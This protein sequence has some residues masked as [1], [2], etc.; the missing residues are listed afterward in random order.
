MIRCLIADD[1]QI[2]QDILE[3]Y[4]LQSTG[5]TLVA[6]CRNALEAFARLEG[7]VVDLIFLDIE[8]PLINGLTFLRSLSN[9]PRVILTTAYADYA[10]EGYELNVV[11]YL[12]K[13]FSF[14]RFSKAIA[15]VKPAEV[16]ELKAEEDEGNLL[17][18]EKGG[19]KRVPYNKIIYIEASKDYM[20]IVTSDQQYL[21]HLT[22]KSLE[23]RLPV[24]R[25]VRI[26]KSYIVSLQQIRMVKSDSVVIGNNQSLP[27]GVNY[28]EQLMEMYK[29]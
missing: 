28:R 25:F 14:E 12:L 27:L 24:E 21:I 18:K 13:P 2:A 17:I 16:F 20:K 1:E 29:K 23:S 19:L 26:H 5:L 11:D 4:I 7:Q 6:K 22:M 9:P 10:L 3:R 15:K 8:M